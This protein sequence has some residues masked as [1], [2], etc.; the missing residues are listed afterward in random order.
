[1]RLRYKP[2]LAMFSLLLLVISSLIK[3]P[4]VLITPGP[5]YSTIGE[6]SGEQF[7]TISGTQTYPTEGALFLT[8]VSEYGGPNEGIDIF[9]AIWGWL[10]PDQEVAPRETFYDDSISQEENRQQNIE[11][12]STSQ[13]YA[14][15][16]ALRYLGLPITKNVVITSITAGAPAVDLLRAGDQVLKVDGVATTSPLEVAEAVRKN[17]VGSTVN[18]LVSRSGSLLDVQVKTAGR[19]DDPTTTENEEGIPYVGIGLDMQYLADFDVQF[20]QTNIGGPSAGMMFGLAIVDLLTPGALTAGN[21]IAG[22]GTIDGEGN[23]GPIGGAGRKLIGAREAGATLFLLPA[24]NCFEVQGDT[25]EGLTVVPVA[26][27]T[28]AIN[29]I[30]DFNSGKEL[31]SCQTVN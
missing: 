23:V 9:Q 12:F 29:A 13:T 21:Q 1:M 14:V 26:T 30:N 16:A 19:V 10:D 2:S 28:E 18:F 25:P 8:T 5:A 11:A 4:Y 3:V 20:A 31:V 7:I 27:L 15:G 17:P 22:T 24:D 6:I